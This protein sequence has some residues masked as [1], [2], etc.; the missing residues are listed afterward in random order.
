MKPV[1]L[2][3]CCTDEY[4]LIYKDHER[5]HADYCKQWGYELIYD[6]LPEGETFKWE[7][8]RYIADILCRKQSPPFLAY[9]DAD[10]FISR[11][12]VDLQDALPEDFWL[13]LVAHPLGQYGNEIHLCVGAQFWRP[14]P[15]ALTFLDTLYGCRNHFENEQHAMNHMLFNHRDWQRGFALLGN[16]WNLNW[17]QFLTTYPITIGWHGYDKGSNA[18]RR[19]E[20]QRKI[21]NLG[22][23][24]GRL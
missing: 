19:R 17:N 18:D 14:H 9:L 21:A 20:I 23:P 11:P 24:L 16:E 3:L 12:G 7:K 22:L 10:S 2:T 6:R 13:G 15:S 5:L 1:L 8:Q 4:E